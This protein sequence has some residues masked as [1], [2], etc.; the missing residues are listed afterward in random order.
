MQRAS[1]AV[2]AWARRR[3]AGRQHLGAVQWPTVAVAGGIYGIFAAI[4]WFH[5]VLPL[6][7]IALVGGYVV[8][9]H[10]SLQHEVIHG[11]PT[12][13][14]RVN[15]AFVFPG[16]WLWLPY[17]LYRESHLRHHRTPVLADPSCDPESFYVSA[18]AWQRLPAPARWL[19]GLNATL[20]GR[21][22]IGPL[23]VVG[24][25]L[26]GEVRALPWDAARCRAWLAHAAGSGL[27]LAWVWGVCG[28]PLGQYLLAVVYPGIALTLLRSYAEHRADPDAA[29]RTAVVAAEAPLAL[30]FLNNNLHTVHH[31][32]PGVPWYRLPAADRAERAAGAAA[33]LVVYRGYRAL[34]R[35]HLLRPID[36]PVYPG[37]AASGAARPRL[38]GAR[39]QVT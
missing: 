23:L 7:L 24:R 30:V 13:W 28:M 11:H 17:G 10:G 19:L 37:A 2:A 15:E 3:A 8:A 22:T 25:F 18:D 14:R 31:A 20:L 27:T 16:L 21:L 29:R 38:N 5:A 26:A 34:A 35:R 32:R 12:P 1:T 33:G 39:A 6:W 9:W 4:T 36:A